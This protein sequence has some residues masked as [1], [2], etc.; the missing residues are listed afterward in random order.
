MLRTSWLAAAGVLA[1]TLAGSQSPARGEVAA[2]PEPETR[3]V[4]AK[5]RFKAGG[6]KQFVLGS[7]YRELWTTPLRVEVLDLGGFSGGLVPKERRGGKQTKGLSL[8]GGDGRKWRFRSV[9][10]DPTPVLPKSVQQSFVADIA[11]DQMSAL[12]PAGVLVANA[13]SAAAQ[14]PHAPARL[15][16][17]PDDPRLGEFR[18]DF[19]DVLGTIEPS[20]RIEPP[21]TPGFSGFDR[22]LNDDEF[23]ELQAGDA[24]QRID[25]RAFLKARMLDLLIGDYDRHE[26]QWEWGRSIHT[27]LWNPVPKDRDLAF[28]KF[29]G[30]MMQVV[31]MEQ[32]R[33]VEFQATLPNPVGIT[34]QARELDRRFLAELSWPAWQEVASELKAQISDAA[35]DA[36]VRHLPEEYHRQVGALLAQQ[37]K[38]RRDALGV[39]SRRVYELLAREAEVHCTNENDTVRLSRLSDGSVRV[40]AAASNG[41]YLQR[42]FLAGETDEVR[43]FLKDGDDRVLSEGPNGRRAVAIHIEGGDGDDSIDATASGK[44]YFYDARGENTVLEG[45][46]TQTSRSAWKHP[47][48]D[49]GQRH[50]DWGSSTRLVPWLHGGSDYGVMLGASLVKVDYGFRKYPHAQRH[51]LK[52]GYST[53]RGT[54][55]ILYDFESRRAEDQGPRFGLTA[56]VSALEVIHYY[57]FGNETAAAEASEFHDVEQRLYLL[58]PAYRRRV[59]GFDVSVG[60]ILKYG[61]TRL[62]SASLIGLDQPYGAGDFGQLGGRLVV[63]TTGSAAFAP[64]TS[65]IRA[66]ADGSFYPALWSARESFG[67]VGGELAGQ[68]VS[69]WPLRPALAVRIRGEK[70]F[71]LYPFHEAASIGGGERLRGL[72][73]QRYVGDA[74]LYGNVELRLTLWDRDDRVIPSFGV[75]G[76]ADCGRVF[77][78][79][80]SSS[81]WHTGVGGGLWFS[82]VERRYL[83]TLAAA[84]SESRLRVYVQGGFLF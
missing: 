42:T 11:R 71:G 75:F 48:D 61:Q 20:P 26:G 36:A 31:R 67:K 54:I 14:I 84:R 29:D 47:R 40:V 46:A 76:L 53:T 73:R 6:L 19:A 16:V 58:A 69:H 37:L 59:M 43:V 62:S 56:A 18:A 65:G 63:T 24:S 32:P 77:L 22:L 83:V 60:P 74:A 44:T 2:V 64:S 27:G 72:P 33:L 38:A 25:A 70:V 21:V 55:P 12:L 8:E 68:L 45:V 50:R 3:R 52:L 4:V 81:R 34:W 7:G 5:P 17:M 1:T 57:G 13:L 80:E 15:V 79:A 9:A 41:S 35:I 78:E 82:V 10:K 39:F 28:V 49:L 30:L 23:E 66:A 51:A